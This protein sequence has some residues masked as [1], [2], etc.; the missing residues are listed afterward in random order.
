MDLFEYILIITSVIFAMAVAQIL[1]GASRVAQSSA[2]FRPFFAHSVWV[3]VLFVFIF[4]V[5]WANWEFRSVDWTFPKYAYMLVTPTLMFF[6]CSL[7]V[8]ADLDAT[9]VDL[10][11]H[12]FA[13]RRP[14]LWSFLIASAAAFVDGSVL[15]D[16]SL[17]YPGRVGQAVVVGASLWGIST[18]NSRSHNAIGTIVL[19]AFAFLVVGRFWIPR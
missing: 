11:A 9:E 19:L 12:F 8:P 10:E 6:A 17:W 18:V 13:I 4:L 1:L 16:E 3:L 7:L 5:W 15:R 2:T 14:L